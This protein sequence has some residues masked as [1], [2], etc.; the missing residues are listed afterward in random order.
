MSC[1]SQAAGLYWDEGFIQQRNFF[2][3]TKIGGFENIFA[4]LRLSQLGDPQHRLH[5]VR[6]AWA[7]LPPRGALT[8]PSL[9]VL[10][11]TATL[12][13]RVGRTE[14]SVFIKSLK[15]RDL[16]V[17]GTGATGIWPKNGLA[18]PCAAASRG[19]DLQGVCARPAMEYSTA[20]RRP[21]SR[22]G[23]FQPR[24]GFVAVLSTWACQC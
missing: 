2:E 14:A 24:R 5:Q 13:P 1:C 21:P 12:R 11:D 22:P 20:R 10:E 19:R 23:H 16:S 15:R 9:L 8:R 3:T 18:F 6:L 4:G 17:T 7:H